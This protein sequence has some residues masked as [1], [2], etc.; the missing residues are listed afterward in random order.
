MQ[1][2][3]TFSADEPTLDDMCIRVPWFSKADW[4]ALCRESP[5]PLLRDKPY[6]AWRK[7]AKATLASIHKTGIKT[8]K[9][10]VDAQ[11]F[12]TWC[13]VRGLPVT[14]TSLAGYIATWT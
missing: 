12:L 1:P 3:R 7:E 8:Y 10:K 9:V 2:L 4:I 6:A 14:H 11:S 5:D 13:H